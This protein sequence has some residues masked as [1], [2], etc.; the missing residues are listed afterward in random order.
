MPPSHS[1][2]NNL[3][4]YSYLIAILSFHA[5]TVSIF[6]YAVVNRE[7]DIILEVGEGGLG[8]MNY[9]CMRTK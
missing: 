5:C 9:V 4:I 7:I 2:L 8:I 1:S 3:T 6:W